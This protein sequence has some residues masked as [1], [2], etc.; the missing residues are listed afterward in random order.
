MEA[1]ERGREWTGMADAWYDGVAAA[2]SP[3]TPHR[4]LVLLLPS[5]PPTSIAREE[6]SETETLTTSALTAALIRTIH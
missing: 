6:T 5:A 1:E 3:S 4:V 2:I